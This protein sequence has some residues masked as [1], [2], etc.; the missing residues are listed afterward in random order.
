[1]LVGACLAM[2][3]PSLAQDT[4]DGQ[5]WVQVLAIAALD[6][7]WRAHVEVQPRMF[8]NATELGLAIGRVALGRQVS[9]R[10]SLWVGYAWVPRTL[11]S[12]TRH[13]QRLWQ[14]LSLA[15]PP[16]SGWTPSVRLRLE[17]RWLEPWRGT[18]HRLRAMVRGQRP[19]RPTSPWSV[20]A[21][22]ELMVT[23]DETSQ[24]PAPGFD[25]NRLYGGLARR[26]TPW[27]VAEAGYIWEHTT[28]AGPLR[29]N[30]HVA[31]AVLSATW[32]PR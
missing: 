27:L 9:P 29:R 19:L 22:D 25:R 3:T 7:D 6:E 8:D 23:V 1:M 31:I 10:V 17:Q 20:A 2:A 24:G 32:P 14:Q 16:R 5:V 4:A 18:S 26:V 28:V 11:G 15:L 21:S 30:D 13:E 12:G